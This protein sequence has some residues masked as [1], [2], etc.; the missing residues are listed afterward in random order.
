MGGVDLGRTLVYA[1]AG[2]AYGEATVAGATLKDNGYFGGL[3]VYYAITDK[4]TVGGEYLVHKFDNFDNSGVDLK[5]D[6]LS[7]KVSFKF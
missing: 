4:F 5:A 7:A 2:A 3:G 6:T 1:T